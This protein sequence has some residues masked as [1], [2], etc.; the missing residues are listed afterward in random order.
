MSS[1]RGNGEGSIG[2]Y[3]GRW[4][5]RVSM[6]GGKRKAIYGRTRSE[7]SRKLA[8]VIRDRD[9]GLPATNDRM[10]V[11]QF[12]R[13]WLE[14]SVRPRN[15]PSTYQSYESHVRVHLVP[16]FGGFSL[17]RLTPHDV[18]QMMSRQIK[19]GLSPATVSRVRATLR[20]ALSQA[21]KKGLVRR[22]V[23]AL[24]EPPKQRPS[25]IEPLKSR[26]AHVLLRAI[27]GH[28]FETLI[29]LALATGLRQGELLGLLWDDVDL[30]AKRLYVRHALQRVQGEFVF[31]EPKTVRSRR[32]VALSPSVIEHLRTHQIAQGR[33][34]ESGGREWNLLGLVFPS[35]AGTPLDGPNVT[36]AFQAV[37]RQA[38][39]PH[40]RFHDLRHACASFML[41]QGASMRVIMEQLGHSQISMTMNTYSHVMPEAMHDAAALME[42]IFTEAE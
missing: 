9:A 40:M 41:A 13:A 1:K 6:P 7:V 12:L 28:R 38:G 14:D 11:G 10:T 36:H 37:V 22:N 29:A 19:E 5:A 17:A 25:R 33:L 8:A 30:D 27:R 3:N 2:F 16:E 21:E 24:A 20:R 35:Q 23:A 15:K 32:Y 34:Q 26:Q 39:L 31:I 42:S 18:E 4:V